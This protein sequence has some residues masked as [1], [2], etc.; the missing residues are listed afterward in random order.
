VQKDKRFA[1]IDR[2]GK[3]ITEYRFD[4]VKRFGEDISGRMVHDMKD[5]ASVAILEPNTNNYK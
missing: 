4:A 3:E 5:L 2:S 1:Y